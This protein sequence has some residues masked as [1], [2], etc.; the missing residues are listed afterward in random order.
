MKTV[1]HVYRFDTTKAEQKTEYT[2]L[3]AKLTAM[4]LKCFKTWGGGEKHY[5]PSWDGLTVTLETASLFDNQWN[6][7]PIA[8]IS[9]IGFRIMDWAQDY[10]IDFPKNI[11][12]GYWI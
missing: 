9:D 11:K 10:P 3:R 12:Q 4:G 6:T 8:G 2:A 7:A 1:I 5:R